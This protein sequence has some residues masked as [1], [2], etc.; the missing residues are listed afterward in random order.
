MG[1]LRHNIQ[2]FNTFFAKL[3]YA[4]VGI[5]IL[6]VTPIS[7]YVLSRTWATAHA[8]ALRDLANEMSNQIDNVAG[9][10]LG[11][12]KL[13]NNPKEPDAWC[14]TPEVRPTNASSAAT[15]AGSIRVLY[16]WRQI[17]L[18]ASGLNDP[19]RAYE[20]TAK[21]R[22]KV[23]AQTESFRVRTMGADAGLD[24]TENSPTRGQ[25]LIYPNGLGNLDLL[26]SDAVPGT[27]V[28]VLAW[29]SSLK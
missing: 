7:D 2:E 4:R 19:N 3:L 16:A 22:A 12:N 5:Q 15:C 28:N 27:D 8:A 17:I 29:L 10:G 13:L 18:S 9:D 1:I 20:D 6:P 26:R 14:S 23:V 11:A 24:Q 25:R 21:Y